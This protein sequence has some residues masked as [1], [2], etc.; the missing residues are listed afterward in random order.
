M[1]TSSFRPSTGGQGSEQRHFKSQAEG[2]D[3]LRQ[4]IRYDYNESNRKQVKE[5]VSAWSQNWLPSATGPLQP[6]RP[7]VTSSHCEDNG[8]S[9]CVP[10]LSFRHSRL[11]IME[12]WC[13][14]YFY[15]SKFTNLEETDTENGTGKAV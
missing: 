10:G 9:A 14:V 11:I 4:P 3:S 2:Q 5:A 8:I 1:L 6:Q 13:K 12:L 7:E 15:Y